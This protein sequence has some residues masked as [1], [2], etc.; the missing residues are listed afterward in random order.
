MAGKWMF[1]QKPFC[2]IPNGFD[3]NKF[4][5]DSEARNQIRSELEIE[6]EYVVGHIG[7]FNDQKNHRFLLEI[8]DKL[9]QI[10]DDI[11]LLLIGNGPDYLQIC[12]LIEKHRYKD[13]IIVYGE[14]NKSRKNV[15]GNGLFCFSI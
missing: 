2:V 13:R 7:Q 6:D 11:V 15:F 4:A 9:A 3:V 1:G 10:N 5:F 12:K 14:T 8:F